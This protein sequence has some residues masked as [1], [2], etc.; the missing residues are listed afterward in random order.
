MIGDPDVV[1]LT[2]RRKEYILKML[3]WERNNGENWIR[4]SEQELTD[5]GGRAFFSGCEV[6]YINENIFTTSHRRGWDREGEKVRLQ[7]RILVPGGE[8]WTPAGSQYYLS[9]NTTTATNT[10]ITLNTTYEGK[11]PVEHHIDREKLI[12]VVTDNKEAYE[13]IRD[14][15][16]ILYRTQMER[17]TERHLAGEISTA[18]LVVKDKDGNRIDLAADQSELHD[19][20]LRALELDSREVVILDHGEYLVWVEDA[21]T[22]LQASATILKRL[23]ELS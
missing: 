3:A 16:H 2:L 9:T 18:S 13:L 14:E 1:P 19:R 15:A 17:L 4:I 10:T 11:T 8:P 20:K 7:Y 12:E 22:N 23:E 5:F 21:D 6:L